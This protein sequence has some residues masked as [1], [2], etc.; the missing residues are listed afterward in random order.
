VGP[1]V[2]SESP[3][4]MSAIQTTATVTDSAVYR[5]HCTVSEVAML[6]LGLP[7]TE[8]D[9]Q[10]T[11]DQGASGMTVSEVRAGSDPRITMATVIVC[12]Y[13]PAAHPMSRH[14]L[15]Q[16][17]GVVGVQTAHHHAWCQ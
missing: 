7:S 4:M 5:R 11:L 15:V 9:I 10:H 13:M 8:I 16:L 12:L 14:R 6:T 17:L 2:D 1:L 3:A